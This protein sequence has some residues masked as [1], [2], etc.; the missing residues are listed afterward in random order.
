MNIEK[1]LPMDSDEL[2]AHLLSDVMAN[3]SAG[4]RLT[5]ELSKTDRYQNDFEFRILTDTSK[6]TCFFLLGEYSKAIPFCRNLV[7]RARALSM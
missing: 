5:E 6:A 2:Y 4:E 7:E 1:Y 3:P